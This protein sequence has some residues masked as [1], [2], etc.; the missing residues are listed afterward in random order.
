MI[1]LKRSPR[2]ALVCGFEGLRRVAIRSAKM[3]R[4]RLRSR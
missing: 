3:A 2:F 4:D 1:E